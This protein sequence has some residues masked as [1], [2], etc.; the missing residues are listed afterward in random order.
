MTTQK[1]MLDIITDNP[2][3]Y[4]KFDIGVEGVVGQY[5]P[6]LIKEKGKKAVVDTTKVGTYCLWLIG[7]K[8]KGTR[9]FT[10]EQNVLYAEALSHPNTI[11]FVKLCEKIN[12]ERTST[13]TSNSLRKVPM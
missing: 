6:V 1:D 8:G 7:A 5:L 4:E 2:E 3:P 12:P 13:S 9:I 10:E 11:R